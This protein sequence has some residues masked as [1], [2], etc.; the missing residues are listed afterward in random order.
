MARRLVVLTGAI[1]LQIADLHRAYQHQRAMYR[2]A[3]FHAWANPLPS[4]AWHQLLPHY[5]HVVLVPSQQCAS[6]PIGFEAPAFLAG[7]HDL[8][9]NSAGV[10]RLD[11][12]KRERYCERL[13]SEIANG[14]LDDRSLYSIDA[15][16][17][18]V[19]SDVAR[20][21]V[22]CGSLDA[23][24]VCVTATSYERWRS[25]VRLN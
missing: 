15:A 21:G 6:T 24:R 20:D 7:L 10:A 13:E 19:L 17:E 9:I 2:S 14:V 12:A 3:E 4:P 25:L 16:H 8:T 22:V 11:Q 23:V 18:V 5:D 1:V